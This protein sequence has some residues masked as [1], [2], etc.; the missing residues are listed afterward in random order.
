MNREQ[1]LEALRTRLSQLPESEI[2]R[3]LFYYDEIISDLIDEG[4]SEYE[5]VGRLGNVDEIAEQILTEAPITTLVKTSV[6]PKRGWTPLAV[7]LAIVGFPV[8]LP[9]LLALFACFIAV[10]VVLFA[11]I[12]VFVA[13]TAAFILGGIALILAAFFAVGTALSDTLM[14][15]GAGLVVIGLGLLLFF[16]AKSVVKSFG[17]LSGAIIRGVK[18]LFIRK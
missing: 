3:S 18:R 8:W 16:A 6:R 12:V 14:M 7:I 10:Y 2:Q 1:F 9:I 11:V 5:A 17:R 13:L 4:F 15:V